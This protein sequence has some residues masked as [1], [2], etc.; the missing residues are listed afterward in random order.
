MDE[1]KTTETT[2]MTDEYRLMTMTADAKLLDEM[3]EDLSQVLLQVSKTARKAAV[4][5]VDQMRVY[6]FV[7]DDL[8]PLLTHKVTELRREAADKETVAHLMYGNLKDE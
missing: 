1:Q 3:A 4:L 2:E 6:G 7:A 8:I 5:S